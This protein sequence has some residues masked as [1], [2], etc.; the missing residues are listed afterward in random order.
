MYITSI[1]TLLTNY[2]TEKENIAALVSVH[3]MEV[4]LHKRPLLQSIPSTQ[5]KTNLLTA[6]FSTTSQPVFLGF[7]CLFNI[8]M[9]EY[10][11]T[12]NLWPLTDQN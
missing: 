11:M 5:V 7:K 3:Y 1:H 4:Y 9:S 8:P 2:H 12:I 10:N 6:T